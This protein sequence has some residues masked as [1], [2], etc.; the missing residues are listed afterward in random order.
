MEIHEDVTM[1]VQEIGLQINQQ[2]PQHYQVPHKVLPKPSFNDYRPGLAK[3]KTLEIGQN[4]QM[5]DKVMSSRDGFKEETPQN[6]TPKFVEDMV[7]R[8]LKNNKIVKMFQAMAIVSLKMG[9]LGLKVHSLKINLTTL[10]GKKQ[11][12][13][14]QMQKEQEGHEEHKK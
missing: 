10:G 13:L 7:A 3:G 11:G 1:D 14:K 4:I 9:N 8:V 12:L 5:W 2:Q 6:L